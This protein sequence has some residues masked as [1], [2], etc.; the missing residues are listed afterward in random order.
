[1]HSKM[2]NP[3]KCLERKAGSPSMCGESTLKPSL[4]KP[5]VQKWNS[6]A[7]NYYDFMKL[8]VINIF[9]SSA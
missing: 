5:C 1:M 2:L 9:S 8:R 6:I 7:S 3:Y 4:S